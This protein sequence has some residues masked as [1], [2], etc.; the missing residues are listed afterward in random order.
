MCR[1]SSRSTSLMRLQPL[2][3]APRAQKRRTPEGRCLVPLGSAV[4]CAPDLPQPLGRARGRRCAPRSQQ[5]VIGSLRPA[6]WSTA[7]FASRVFDGSPSS[8]RPRPAAPSAPSC[9]PD[10]STS[11]PPASAGVD[12]SLAAISC[13]ACFAFAPCA[14][15]S[16]Q[17]THSRPPFR[18]LKDLLQRCMEEIHGPAAVRRTSRTASRTENALHSNG[19]V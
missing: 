9:R 8:S 11:S 5:A 3:S 14:S 16:P 12:R 19:Y 7:T 15:P 10:C 6:L 18:R 4:D 1:R 17:N 2:P 13:P